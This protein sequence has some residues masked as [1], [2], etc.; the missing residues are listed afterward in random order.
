MRDAGRRPPS[1]AH[2]EHSDATPARWAG[3][4]VFLAGSGKTAIEIARDRVLV[5][6]TLFGIGFLVLA[7]RVVD[8]AVVGAPESST[9]SASASGRLDVAGRADIVDRNGIVLATSLRTHSLYADARLIRDPVTVANRLYDIFTDLDR[10]ELVNRFAARRS[11]IW[12]KRNLTP[13]QVRRVNAL[14]EPGLEFLREERRVYPQGPLVAHI[15]GQSGIDN[16]GLTG[17]ER[18]QDARLRR[19]AGV[20][21]SLSIDLRVQ[22]VLRAEILTAMETFQAIGAAGVVVDVRTGEVVAMASLPDYD[23]NKLNVADRDTVFNRAT[24]G[25]YEMGSTFKAFTTA[26]ALDAGTVTLRDGYDATKPLKVSRFLIRDYHAKSRWLSVPEIFMYSSNIGAAKMALDVG[27]DGQRAFLRRAGLLDPSTVELPEISE[28]MLPARWNDISIATISFGHG[29]AVSPV[30]LTAGIGALVNDGW[31]APTTVLRVEDQARA[32]SVRLCGEATSHSMRQL[33]RLVVARGTGR[34]AEAAGYFVG[35]KTG[36]A[37]K[38]GRRGYDR[39]RLISSFV[40]AF[41]I[42][43]PEYAVLV[44]IDEPKGTKE[45]HFYAT[46]GWTAAPVVGRVI[47]QIGPLLGVTPRLPAEL[48]AAVPADVEPSAPDALLVNLDGNEIRLA[49]F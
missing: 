37:E 38:P 29:V 25:V 8:V 49:A 18:S 33:M 31:L 30:Q 36:T 12:V 1:Q 20:P 17:I 3:A 27:A 23:P 21:L 46:G 4:R 42:D 13:L 11:F 7:G 10:N 40:A 32:P 26:M 41:P 35:G 2:S 5:M 6:A 22:H 16:N 9:K 28:P 47:R 34:K 14:G 19:E 24:L 39:K 15:V 44:L 45:T 48:P 43:R